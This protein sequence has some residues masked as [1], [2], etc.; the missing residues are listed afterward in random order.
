MNWKTVNGS[1]LKQIA[2]GTVAIITICALTSC[3]LMQVAKGAIVN[4]TE[5][6]PTTYP[7]TVSDARQY[8]VPTG[9]VKTAYQVKLAD[10]TDKPTAKDMSA[11]EAAELGAQNLWRLFGVNMDGKTVEMTYRPAT[12]V[13]PRA[14]WMGSVTFDE[15]LDYWFVVDAITGEY[16][17]THK[18]K[19]WNENINTGMDKDLLNNHEQ[20]TALA[21]ETAEK[22]QLVSG[23]VVSVEYGSQGATR[24]AAG[25]KNADITMMVKSDNG[26]Q[27]Q[28]TFSRYNQE[29]L[30]VEYDSWLKDAEE[31]EKEI[32]KEVRKKAQERPQE[33]TGDP[34]LTIDYSC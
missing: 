23:Q 25:A 9:Y 10:S 21:K 24:N 1:N 4:K 27:A 12:A 31:L 26:Q 5:I 16:R 32:T 20:Y 22:Y 14:E 18:S 3:G 30:S 8:G 2:V 13:Q 28:L 33:S 17:S 29:F 15:N 34:I 11:E 7:S 6:I 19:Y